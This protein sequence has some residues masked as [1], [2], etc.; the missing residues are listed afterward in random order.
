MIGKI[1]GTLKEYDE[2]V[3]LIESSGGVFFQVYLTPVFMA[4]VKIGTKIEVYTYLQVRED[5]LK[6]FGFELKKEL[7]LFK[8]LIGVPGVG[9][10]TAYS[11]ICYQTVDKIL[12]AVKENNS[13]Y[14]TLVPGLGRK[15]AMKIILELSQK[16]NQEF[17]LEK[18]YL[19]EDDR[20]VVDALISLGY[21][22]SE[23]KKLLG[24]IPKNLKPEQRVKAA[25][26]LIK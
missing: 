15:T 14:L 20:T 7:N 12:E 4:Q 11:V 19:S 10:K 24:K 5:A 26:Q 18:M 6:L 8:M 22:S 21:K 2:N 23:A 17:K 1:K 9:P 16:L 3:G 25:L 13:D